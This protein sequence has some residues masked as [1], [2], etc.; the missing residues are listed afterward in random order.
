MIRAHILRTIILSLP[1]AIAACSSSS[2]DTATPTGLTGAVQNQTDDPDGLTVDFSFSTPPTGAIAANFE[3]DGG[4]TAQS[5]TIVG[6]VAS[7]LWDERVTPSHQ[8]RVVGLAGVGDT[9]TGVS[10][11]NTTAPDFTIGVAN[12]VAGHGGDNFVVTFTGPR[13]I[14]T[15]AETPGNWTL[16]VGGQTL[17]MTGSVLDLDPNTQV[18]TVTLGAGAN[19]HSTFTFAAA[20]LTSV[21]DVA[22]PT[23]AKNGTANGDAAAPSLVSANQ[24]LIADEFGR[25]VDYTF[26][27]AM[28]PVF[29]ASLANFGI[30]LPDIAT[31]VTLP[32]ETV[33]RVT[34]SRPMIPGTDSVNLQ[35]LVDAHGNAYAGGV[36]PIAQPSPTANGYTT[37]DAVTV[38]NL[39]NDYI[40]VVFVQALVQDECE[41]PTNWTLTVDGNPVTMNNQTLTYDLLTKNLRIDLDFD[42]KNGDAWTLTPAGITEVDGE[43]FVTAATG[44]AD[45]DV[46]APVASVVLQNRATDPTGVTLDV[47][48]S[49]DLETAPAQ[50]IANWTLTGGLSV[51]SATLLPNLNSVRL[52][53]DGPV[54]PGDY[55]LSCDNLE[56]L[57][58][59]VMASAQ[60]GL[61]VTSTDSDAPVAVSSSASSIQGPDNDRII[62]FFNDDMISTEITNVTNWTFESPIG[63]DLDLTGTTITYDGN[64]RRATLV[65]DGSGDIDLHGMDTYRI[66]VDAARDI[67]GNTMSAVELDGTVAGETRRPY[68]DYAWYDSTEA[69]EVVV[70]F[71]EHCERLD[72]LYDPISNVA[73]SRYDLYD[74]GDSFRG[75]PVAATVLEDGLGVRLEYGFIVNPTDLLRVMGISDLAGNYSFPNATPIALVAEDSSEAAH[76]AVLTPIMAISGERN[77]TLEVRFD[78]PMS[79]WGI[80][81]PANYSV[82]DGVHTPDLTSASFA[83]DGDRTVMITLDSQTYDS[84]HFGRSY[85]IVVDGLR[86][87]QGVLLSGP[88]TESTVATAGDS[89]APTVGVSDVRVDPV[90]ADSVI[91]TVGEALDRTV[92]ETASNYNY[93]SGSIATSAELIEPRTVRVT[94]AVQPTAGFNIDISV[95][96]LAQNAT[97][98]LT[99][100]VAVSE[101]NTPLLVSVSGVSVPGIGGDTVTIVFNEPVEP[102]TATD[103]SNYSITNGT[104]KSLVGAEALYQSSTT[105]V[106]L[107][108]ASGV[109]LDATQPINVSVA[110]VT[111]L[112]G[113]AMSTTPVGLAGT[114]TGDLAAP[115]VT[116]A[117]VNFRAETNGYD[118]D[119]LFSEDVDA[120]FATDIFN[121]TCSGGQAVIDV[122]MISGDHA[123]VLLLAPIVDG[124]NI[125]IA[126]GLPDS[127]GNTAGAISAPISY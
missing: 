118:V 44:N 110:N 4:Q 28:D 89:I 95:T 83:F 53:C 97:G 58:G 33:V 126:A 66:G 99:R 68:A 23:T 79:P 67:A 30:S 47:T 71:S 55:T 92:A 102:G 41:D 31:S 59:T 74:S 9:W 38:T 43:S 6:N 65:L 5:V 21:A 25:V 125:E 84:F 93:N 18:M 62:V 121:W 105:S 10:T 19:L 8:V 124:D 7:V 76:D 24:N 109:E 1:L 3:A 51:I 29:C 60:V 46:T 90:V 56:D 34:F 11:S 117:F 112:S 42:M 122:Q 37:E 111:D 2:S 45:G 127:A 73:G 86:T 57:A 85:D 13:V 80:E 17:D 104:A 52:V 103:L 72:D 116:A 107:R 87:A 91:V 106:T 22:V 61:V 49:E 101:S 100:T 78:L 70:Y 94:F 36:T 26:D 81:D 32:S 119:V 69:D 77:D 64:V 123:H 88:I 108:L 20:S 16:T 120:A 35:N 27:E 96:D 15:A 63:T 39:G 14:E 48:L 75:R 98:V 82:S 114:V 113:N 40:D 50:N 12:M 54:I 115:S